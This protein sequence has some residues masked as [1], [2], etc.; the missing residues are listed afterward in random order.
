MMHYSERGSVTVFL[1]IIF[2]ALVLLAGLVFDGG[3]ALAAK[4]HAISAADGAARA[5][6]QAMQNNVY[7]EKGDVQFDALAATNAGNA[8]LEASGVSGTV[9]VQDGVVIAHTQVPQSMAILGLVGV[10]PFNLTGEGR[11]RLIQGVRGPAS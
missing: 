5:G 2:F 10:G 8:Y 4:M 3:Y 6:A 7:R 1:T 11:S 9:E